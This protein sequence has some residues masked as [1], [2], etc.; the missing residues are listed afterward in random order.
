MKKL[1]QNGFGLIEGLLI[2]IAVILLG[3]GGYYVYS[4]NKDDDTNTSV[5]EEEKSE[6]TEVTDEKESTTSDVN[7]IEIPE[8]GVAFEI[9]GTDTLLYGVRTSSDDAISVGFTTQGDLDVDS[10]CTTD[11]AYYGLLT[12]A[13]PGTEYRDG[14]TYDSLPDAK[15]LD[16][17]VYAYLPSQSPCTFGENELTLEPRVSEAIKNTLELL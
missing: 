3:F 12:R 10:T 6:K 17:Y 8:L 14:F 11:A 2:L 13:V 5:V 16:G 9:G 4:Q 7:R 15:L 1:E